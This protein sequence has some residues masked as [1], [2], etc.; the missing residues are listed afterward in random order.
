MSAAHRTVEE[1]TELFAKSYHKSVEQAEECIVV[2]LFEKYVNERDKQGQ[3]CAVDFRE[4][5]EKL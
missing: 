5:Y 2:S 1:Y 4:E 3:E